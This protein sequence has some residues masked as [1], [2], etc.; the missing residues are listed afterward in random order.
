MVGIP[1]V[2]R[3]PRGLDPLRRIHVPRD[4]E[5]ITD[6]GPEDS[7][8]DGGVEQAAVETMWNAAVDW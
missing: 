8:T 6:I 4:L 5:S 3:F 1:S 7:A 2:P